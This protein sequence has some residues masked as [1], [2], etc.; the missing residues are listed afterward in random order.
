MHAHKVISVVLQSA[1]ARLAQGGMH[2]QTICTTMWQRQRN[3]QQRWLQ[4]R[5][6]AA[7]DT[8]TAPATVS[9]CVTHPRRRSA[10]AV[11][12]AATDTTDESSASSSDSDSSSA[13]STDTDESAA[14][15]LQLSLSLPFSVDADF[16]LSQ[17][18]VQQQELGGSSALQQA[19]PEQAGSPP[20]QPPRQLQVTVVRAR[21][22]SS[23]VSIRIP[24]V[25]LR[26]LPDAQ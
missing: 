7:A 15:E 20:V 12:A 26:A 1:N 5:G 8:K 13:S 21:S 23:P 10:A 9:A 17:P 19:E 24:R 14:G 4:S 18:A 2:A 11:R 22:T 6:Q 16:E 25:R 3:S